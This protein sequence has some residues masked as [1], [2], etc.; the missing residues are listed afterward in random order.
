MASECIFCKIASGE[1]PN[2]KLHQ[3]NG[4]FVIADI[5]PQA[6]VHLLVI[7]VTHIDSM[8]EFRDD[9]AFLME[10]MRL[11]AKCAAETAGVAESG[12]RLVVNT[13]KDGGQSVAHLHMHLLAGRQMSD[14]M[15]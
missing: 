14:Q 13:G 10:N 11:M 3:A 2:E 1:L 4:V 5:N 15:G 12:Y 8:A 7:P 9:N 6:P